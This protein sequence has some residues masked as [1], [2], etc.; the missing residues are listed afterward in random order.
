LKGLN[1]KNQLKK[2]MWNDE[3]SIRLTNC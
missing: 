3:E 1:K 2:Y